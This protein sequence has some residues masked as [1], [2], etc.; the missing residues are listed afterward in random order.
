MKN[1]CTCPVVAFGDWSFGEWSF[2]KWS[3]SEIGRILGVPRIGRS[4]I[5]RSEIGR[6]ENGRS[7]IN[8]SEN[9]RC[10]ANFVKKYSGVNNTAVPIWQSSRGS[11][12]LPL[13]GILGKMFDEKYQRSKIS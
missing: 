10:Y 12:W 7:E 1:T 11:A 2:E 5:G 3:H 9:G 13:N 8:R 4:E 6:S